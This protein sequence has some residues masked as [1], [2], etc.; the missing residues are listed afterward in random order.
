MKLESPCRHGSPD[1]ANFF[2][3]T[4]EKHPSLPTD[5]DQ[6]SSGCE[7]C[8]TFE[9]PRYN[10][11]RHRTKFSFSNKSKVPIL[12]KLLRIPKMNRGSFTYRDRMPTGA[13]TP[14]CW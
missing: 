14:F 7:R 2:S 6:T 4:G 13:A 12:S 10:S 8:I 3:D 1:S 11:T 5:F 9:L